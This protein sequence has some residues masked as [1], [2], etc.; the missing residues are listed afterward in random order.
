MALNARDMDQTS[1]L[2]HDVANA[3]E[4]AHAMTKSSCLT[5]L[6]VGTICWIHVLSVNFLR[7]LLHE[8]SDPQSYLTVPQPYLTVPQPYL[9]VPQPYLTVPQCH[10]PLHTLY[11]DESIVYVIVYKTTNGNLVV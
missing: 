8:F 4:M 1:Y 10:S 9:M 3:Y 6:L 5:L 11:H 2:H 7:F